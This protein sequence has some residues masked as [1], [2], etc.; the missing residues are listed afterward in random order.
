MNIHRGICNRLLW[1]QDAYK[2]TQD[3]RVLQKTTFSFDV[4]VWEFFW[5][6]LFG[7]R[8]VV[9]EPGGH[10]DTGYLVRTIV[11]EKITTMHFVPSMMQVFLE[12]KDV[13]A[14]KSLRRVICSG[15]ALPYD[16]QERF[17]ELLDAELHNLY[18]PTEAAVDV[19]CWACRRGSKLK[20]VPIGRPIA[21]TQTY[22]LNQY[23]QPVPVGVSG[24]L[25]LGGVQI[26]RG[27][28]NRPDLTSEKFIPDPF[29]Q[30]PTAR[31]YKTG[32]LC[33]HLPDGNIEYLGRNDFQVKIRGQRIE[34]GEIE[35]VLSQMPAVREV[36]VLAREDVPGDK[37]L[38]A[39]IVPG[40]Q[41][42]LD[43]EELRNAA[44]EKLP[45]YM[46]P[47]TIVPMVAFSLTSSGKVDRRSLP[48][49]ER[50]R[51]I[52]KSFVAPLSETE[53]I[54]ERIWAEL[55]QVDKVGATD[56]FFDLGGHSLLLVK[57]VAKVE[58]SFSRKVSIIELF[59][60]PSIKALAEFLS[61][62]KK[63]EPS[64]NRIQERA[65]KQKE[66]LKSGRQTFMR[67]GE[68]R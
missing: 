43:L 53:K 32:D 28:L 54:L 46:I 7:A 60:R 49:P 22:I 44:K 1:M 48:V 30:E 38:V 36:V 12:D 23:M 18:G 6:L 55:L 31:L 67:R 26:A 59:Q 16:L 50:K 25:H 13:R 56:N 4:S 64:F 34:I 62:E 47:S 3:D 27:Y 8:L 10:R 17:F 52:D 15:E 2:L 33:R 21:N 65:M 35:S 20:M 39:Y 42:R 58:E 9:A 57:M 5:P 51:Q 68:S 11:D 37:R 45:S 61:D 40:Q 66:M 19:T 41:S 63:G 29:S 24:E 14:C